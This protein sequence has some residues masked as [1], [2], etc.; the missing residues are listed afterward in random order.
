MTVSEALLLLNV[1]PIPDLTIEKIGIDR[2]LVIT[3]EYSSEIGI[4]QSFELASADTYMWLHDAPSIVEQEVGINSAIVIKQELKNR[5]N[6]IY[7]KYRE[8]SI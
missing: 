8:K 7:N 6:L 1:Y 2:E 3:A 4:S 5:A